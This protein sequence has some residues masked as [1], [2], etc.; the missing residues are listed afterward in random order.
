MNVFAKILVELTGFFH[1][2]IH[3]NLNQLSMDHFSD[4]RIKQI[5]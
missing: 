4:R 1:S 5:V 3:F 2:S